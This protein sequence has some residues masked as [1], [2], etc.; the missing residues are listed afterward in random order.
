MKKHKYTILLVILSILFLLVPVVGNFIDFGEGTDDAAGEMIST[1]VPG[2]E[3]MDF[4]FGYEPSET[5]EPVLFFVQI[6]IGI[7]IFAIAY[8]KL[9]K[10]GS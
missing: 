3:P 5:M 2:F 4:S 7:A 8:K 6:V 9:V 10:K 1:L